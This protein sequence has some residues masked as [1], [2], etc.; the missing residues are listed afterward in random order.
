MARLSFLRELAHRA[1]EVIGRENERWGR[2]IRVQSGDL[3]A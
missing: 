3:P 1:V 2:L